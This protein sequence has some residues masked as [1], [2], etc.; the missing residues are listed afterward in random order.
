MFDAKYN[1]IP[2]TEAYELGQ[3]LLASEPLLSV[4]RGDSTLVGVGNPLKM[5]HPCGLQEFVDQSSLTKMKSTIIQCL[6]INS[7]ELRN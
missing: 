7:Q 2:I 3:S 1:I 6:D 5:L 4:P